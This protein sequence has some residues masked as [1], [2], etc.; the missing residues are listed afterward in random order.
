MPDSDRLKTLQDLAR[1][2]G[3]EDIAQEVAALAERTA[4]GRFYVACVGQ[5]KRGKSTLLNALIG[6]RLLPAGVV[7]ITAA[8]TILRHG[9]RKARI[10][11]S[12]GKWQEV[13]PADLA[14][15]VSEERNPEN[16]KGV[17]AVEVF[18]PSPLLQSGL[19]L[20]DTP[21]IGSVF[22]GNTAV[23][24][25]F[26]PHIDAAL[27]VVGADPPISGEEL[28]LVEDVGR[29]VR[30][31]IFILSKADRLSATERREAIAFTQRT[32][33]KRLGRLA[34]P[35]LEVS[36]IE[37]LEGAITH[38][39]KRLEEVLAQLASQSGAELVRTAEARGVELLAA[40]ILHDL[41]EQKG[42]L[43]RPLHESEARV[44]TLKQCAAEAEIAMRELGYRLTAEE[45]R[46]KK[47]FEKRR[48]SFVARALPESHRELNDALAKAE[49]RGPA[50]RRRA[51]ALAQ[52]L[53]KR[54]IEPRLAEEQA[55][56]E[57]MYRESM[58]RFVAMANQFLERLASSGT[59]GLD[60]LPRAIG[61][62]G[63]RVKS[64][65]FLHELLTIVPQS[66]WTRIGDSLRSREAALAA[67]RK[68]AGAYLEHMLKTNS[69][70]VENDLTERVLESRRRLE[71]EIRAR[72]KEV[73]ASA[74][75]ALALARARLAE[76][77]DA[78]RAELERVIR[79]RAEVE[80]L[81]SGADSEERAG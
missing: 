8:V 49:E 35:I 45:E 52:E 65:F 75:S 64:R 24:R 78:V 81:R 37:R 30:D 42:A 10:R 7:P 73:Y 28:T 60:S 74:E 14:E 69:S 41:D 53:S 48:L 32:V 1:Q 80:H 11:L 57:A 50:L 18:L 6:E 19:C 4:E 58:K 66:I 72:L 21:G 16:Q 31:L 54:W 46:L 2:T 22:A 67:I 38:D 12:D 20:V 44:A 33:A 71:A 62:D 15:Y 40:R 70:R 36:A 5:F 51:V 27:V 68:A 77:A 47:E 9:E 56:A 79:L 61:S 63:F 13:D 43:E 17:V 39:W 29:Q 3:R 76:G 23:T 59:P 25:E 26:V 55:A 34:G